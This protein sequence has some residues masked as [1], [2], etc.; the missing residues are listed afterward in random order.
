MFVLAPADL[1]LLTA[2]SECRQTQFCTQASYRVAEGDQSTK[3]CKQLLGR[4]GV[5]GADL[6]LLDKTARGMCCIK[7]GGVSGYMVLAWV[8][9]HHGV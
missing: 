3:L 2:E 6:L 8:S 1:S 4:G 5:V 7:Y 9:E